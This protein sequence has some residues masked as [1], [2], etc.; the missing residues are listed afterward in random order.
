M[1]ESQGPIYYLGWAQLIILSPFVFFAKAKLT[2]PM[3]CIYLRVEF[4]FIQ[5]VAIGWAQL[6]IVSQGAMYFLRWAQLMTLSPFVFCQIDWAPVLYSARMGPTNPD[7]TGRRMGPINYFEPTLF[8]HRW[9]Q[10]M[11]PTGPSSLQPCERDN[12][13]GPSVSLA[14]TKY[15]RPITISNGPRKCI[16]GTET[17]GPNDSRHVHVMHPD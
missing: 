13:L 8:P 14:G 12:W 4:D 9:A 6:M 15:S 1:I 3:C 16:L 5:M 17:D 7:Q 2:G 11:I 10:L